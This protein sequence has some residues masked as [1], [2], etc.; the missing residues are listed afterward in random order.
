MSRLKLT[1]AISPQ[2]QL[3]TGEEPNET[4]LLCQWAL[5]GFLRINI[6]NSTVLCYVYQ[7]KDSTN[8]KK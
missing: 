2:F 8:I 7:N 4:T 1:W 6:T 5:G 3:W